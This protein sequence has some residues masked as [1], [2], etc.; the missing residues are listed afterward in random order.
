MLYSSPAANGAV[1]V[2]EPVMTVQV[3][4]VAVAVGAAGAPGGLLMVTGVAGEVQFVDITITVTLYGPG[5]SPVKI[6]DA[7]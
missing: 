1:T 3:G 7:W 6:A 2:I 5:A 4:C